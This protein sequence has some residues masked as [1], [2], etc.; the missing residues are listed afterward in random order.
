MTM[1]NAVKILL[2][3]L[4]CLAP[5]HAAILKLEGDLDWEITEP[6][7]NFTL[8]G[9]IRNL[10]PSGTTSGTIKLVLWATERPFPAPGAVVGEYTLGQ[11]G[12]G[13]QFSD[14]NVRTF[15]DVPEVTGAYY[16]TVTVLEYT[17]AGWRTL[18]AEPTGTRTL[19][20]GD[21]IDQKKWK[22]PTLPVTPPPATLQR[23]DFLTL[24]TKATVELNQ[25]PT[26]SQSRATIDV[27]TRSKAILRD[28]AK[29]SGKYTYV[30]GKTRLNK[31]KARS[32]RINLDLPAK[33][34][35]PA[36]KIAVTLWFHQANSGI[37]RSTETSGSF[38]EIVW[39]EFSFD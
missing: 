39:G 14:F 5:L 15:S 21:F 17:T 20:D 2:A 36:R 23:G 28:P 4:T 12:G 30:S 31:K 33:G 1:R 35:R 34:V 13:Y 24:T 18:I 26:A 16:F 11:V 38:K 7:C 27:R 3:L 37:Y 9:T 22:I 19:K 32:G 25:L 8:D 10:S 6:R 29:R